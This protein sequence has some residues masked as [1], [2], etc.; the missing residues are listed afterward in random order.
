MPG[1]HPTHGARIVL[2]LAPTREGDSD[3]SARYDVEIYEPD[4]TLTTGEA[5]LTPG[6]ADVTMERPPA[7]WIATF[8]QR[9]LLSLD[10]KHRAAGTWPRKVTRWRAS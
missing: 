7:A 9:L 8:T 10:G 4:E 6:K 3:A 1:L 5:I 2:K